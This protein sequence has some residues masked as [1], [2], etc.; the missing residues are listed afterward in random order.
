VL[1]DFASSAPVVRVATQHVG[2][3]GCLAGGCALQLFDSPEVGPSPQPA[4]YDRRV[5]KQERPDGHTLC[6]VHTTGVHGPEKRLQLPVVQPL[7]QRVAELPF[8]RL[9][10]RGRVRGRR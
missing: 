2:L 4:A 9:N 5:G 10:R 1:T 8:I 7:E 6:R 3:F